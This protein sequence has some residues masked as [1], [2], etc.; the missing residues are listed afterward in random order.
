MTSAESETDLPTCHLHPDRQ[1]GR[2]CSRC[3]RPA[4]PECLHAASVGSHCTECVRLTR[5][6]VAE[7]VR[8]RVALAGPVVT[9]AILALNVAMFALTVAWAAVDGGAQ[10][11]QRALGG[12][13]TI[14]HVHLALFRSL[15]AEGEWYRVFSSS[16]MHFGVIHLAMNMFGLFILGRLLEPALG[17]MRFASLYLASLVGGTLGAL[18]ISPDALTAGAS[19]ALYGLLG[20]AFVI[21][22]ARGVDPFS[23]GLGSWMVVALVWTFVAPG[24]SIGGHLGGLVAGAVTGYLMVPRHRQLSASQSASIGLAMAGVLFV[25]CL[26]VSTQYG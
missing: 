14:A 3:G 22:K 25:A 17:R 2:R 11:A 4:C 13:I 12:E 1:T 20:G 15:V 23:T 10:Q 26:L 21:M 8:T 5:P 6:P 18:W 9:Y 24:V 7:R 16:F 19:G